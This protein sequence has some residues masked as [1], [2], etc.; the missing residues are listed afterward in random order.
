MARDIGLRYAR[1]AVAEYV[2]EF[3]E[4]VDPHPV[5]ESC[6]AMNED[7]DRLYT[8]NAYLTD[9]VNHYHN[10]FGKLADVTTDLAT[11]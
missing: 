1:L 11:R 8:E 6:E 9:M 4:V 10:R 2:R 5:D 7:L 3:G